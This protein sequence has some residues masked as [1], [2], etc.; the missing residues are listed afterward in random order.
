MYILND[1]ISFIISRTYSRM[2]NIFLKK[3]NENGISDV[4]DIKRKNVGLKA[5][6]K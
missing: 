2:K 3:L 4:L 5:K 1:A 6:N